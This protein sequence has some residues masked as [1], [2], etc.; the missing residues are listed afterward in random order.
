MSLRTDFKDEIPAGGSRKYGLVDNSGNYLYRDVKIVRTNENTQDGDEFGAAEV[1]TIHEYLNSMYNGNLLINGDFQVWQRGTD[2]ENVTEYIYTVDRWMLYGSIQNKMMIKKETKGASII[3]T[4]VQKLE[5]CLRGEI[6]TISA[7][8]DGHV[9]KTTTNAIND[10]WKSY[11]VNEDGKNIIFAIQTTSSDITIFEMYLQNT[12][13]QIPYH[14]EWIKMEYGEIDTPSVSRPYVEELLLCQS[15]YVKFVASFSTYPFWS[16]TRNDSLMLD[17]A[18]PAK[19]GWI[20]TI[21]VTNGSIIDMST[22]TSYSYDKLNFAA[23]RLENNHL[24]IIVKR[25]DGGSF[26]SSNWVTSGLDI[27]IDKE[28]Y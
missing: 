6:V 24:F 8:I 19:M 4:A 23:S 5:L 10:T 13:S 22:G 7:K 2:F 12:N 21:T 27:Q 26:S 11:P 14:V 9:F 20:P 17:L 16:N 25:N 18:L 28:I 3:G 1:N 15:R